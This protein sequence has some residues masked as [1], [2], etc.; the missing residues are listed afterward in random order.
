MIQTIGK[1][2]VDFL[3][4]LYFQLTCYFRGHYIIINITKQAIYLYSSNKLERTYAIS[5]GK[6]GSGEIDESGKTPRGWLNIDE[7]IGDQ[8]HKD[9][10]FISREAKGQ[11]H[12]DMMNAPKDVIMTR[13]LWLDG[14]QLCNDNTKKRYIY[15]HATNEVDN[16]GSSPQSHGCIR[17]HPTDIVELFSLCKKNQPLL[18]CID[19]KNLLPWQ[20]LSTFGQETE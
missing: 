9:T 6:N 7:Y 4:H 10:Y 17:L 18:Y 2:V 1:N 16:L 12:K 14:L 3:L 20:T 19:H 15:C 13:I 8:A 11:Y 5:S